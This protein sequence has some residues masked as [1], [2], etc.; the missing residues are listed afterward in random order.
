MSKSKTFKL[1]NELTL[2]YNTDSWHSDGWG[3][4]VGGEVFPDELYEVEI[5]F[6]KKLKPIE[7]GQLVEIYDDE[8][9]PWQGTVSWF[10]SRYALIDK[11]YGEPKVVKRENIGL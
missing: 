4:E 2:D 5:T 1:S 11:T 9:Y 3:W 6:T 7:V 8:S 10:D